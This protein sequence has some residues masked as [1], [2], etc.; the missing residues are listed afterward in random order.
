MRKGRLQ[1]TLPSCYEL[2]QNGER[3]EKNTFLSQYGFSHPAMEDSENRSRWRSVFV[4]AK[5]H[6]TAMPTFRMK[7]SRVYS[8]VRSV[9]I[10]FLPNGRTQSPTDH[11]AVHFPCYLVL[12]R[13]SAGNHARIRVAVFG[14]LLGQSN[15]WFLPSFFTS[16][17]KEKRGW[18]KWLT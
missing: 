5:P 16:K 15:H 9:P 18:R 10:W 14:T 12:N 7:N 17:S 13:G 4:T 6:L 8:N 3:L 2:I 1:R 11:P